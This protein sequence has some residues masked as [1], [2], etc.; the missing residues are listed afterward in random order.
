MQAG[1]FILSERGSR[2]VQGRAKYTTRAANDVFN[3]KP[4]AV[5]RDGQGQARSHWLSGKQG[6]TAASI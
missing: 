5:L 3:E 6:V 1:G 4:P 2:M